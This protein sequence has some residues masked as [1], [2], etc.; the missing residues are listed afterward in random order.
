[1]HG[2]TRAEVSEVGSLSWVRH[3]DRLVELVRRGGRYAVRVRDPR[4]ATRTAF[5]GAPSFDVDPVWAP[6]GRATTYYVPRWVVVGSACDDLTQEITLV[7]V[8]TVDILGTSHQLAATAGA[9]GTLSLAFHD[10]PTAR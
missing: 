8:V 6:P 5:R 10:E 4:A 9:A 2:T 1:M 7:G 3:G